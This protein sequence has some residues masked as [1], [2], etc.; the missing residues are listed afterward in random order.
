MIDLDEY[1]WNVD[2][3]DELLDDNLEL[4]R[5]HS[6]IRIFGRYILTDANNLSAKFLS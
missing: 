4:S 2:H 6:L 1:S 5:M 3:L